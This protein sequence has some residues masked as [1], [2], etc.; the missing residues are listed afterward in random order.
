MWPYYV[1]RVVE[2]EYELNLD[3]RQ[4]KNANV[5]IIITIDLVLL[6]PGDRVLKFWGYSDSCVSVDC[7]SNSVVDA[8]ILM[9]R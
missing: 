3:P 8:C 1:A 2:R 9:F 4:T 6:L 5:I 7:S